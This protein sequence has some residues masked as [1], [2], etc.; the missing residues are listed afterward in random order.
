LTVRHSISSSQAWM[1]SE[2]GTRMRV[3][4]GG[5][6][7]HW[8]VMCLL[9]VTADMWQWL[10]YMWLQL[11]DSDELLLYVCVCE[12]MSEWVSEWVIADTW[13]LQ[14]FL[15]VMCVVH[16]CGHIIVANRLKAYIQHMSHKQ[17]QSHLAGNWFR[18][19]IQPSRD[20]A[21]LKNI[22]EIYATYHYQEW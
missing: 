17:Q 21:W 18:L 2:R 20:C 4:R 13:H 8:V 3:W 22:K 6:E 10:C 11:H 12:W 7:L 15:C 1:R 19:Y 16:E 5:G 14:T 9:Y